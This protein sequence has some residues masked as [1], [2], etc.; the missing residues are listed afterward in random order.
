MTVSFENGLASSSI[1][2]FSFFGLVFSVAMKYY[3]YMLYE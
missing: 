1:L 2:E 3:K